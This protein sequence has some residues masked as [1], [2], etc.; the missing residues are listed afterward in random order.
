MLKQTYPKCHNTF[1]KWCNSNKSYMNIYKQIGSPRP[2]DVSL[3]DGLQSLKP[4]DLEK[5]KF[6]LKKKLYY[7]I[8]FTH[9]P[10]NIEVGSVVSKNV[11][12]VLA[13]SMDLFDYIE[14]E[15]GIIKKDMLKP[16]NYILIPNSKKLETVI[17]KSY[18]KNFSFITSVSNNFQEKNTKKNL[19]ETRKD[20]LNMILILD[21]ERKEKEKEKE[22]YNIKLYISCINEC[23]IDG[24]IDNDFIVHEILK[25]SKFNIDNFCLSDTCGTLELDDFEY[26]VDTCNYFGL[27]FSKM[28]L[29]L[30]VKN[31]RKHIVKQIIQMAIS[32][33]INVF[34]VSILESGGCSVTIDKNKLAPNLSYDLFYESIVDYIEKKNN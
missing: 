7:D 30:H 16:N 27:P 1:I 17:R 25:Y 19:D 12:P 13:D 2:F 28:S 5:Y 26:I 14:V 11:L 18:L 4:D 33:K 15:S 23:P 24:K 3:R 21:N 34:D 32:K 6:S 29:H 22:N 8:Y 31:E 9:F 10:E 20:I